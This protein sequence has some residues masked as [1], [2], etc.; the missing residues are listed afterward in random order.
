MN[1]DAIKAI[2]FRIQRIAFDA[3]LY[4]RGMCGNEMAKRR[5]DERKKLLRAIAELEHPQL[6]L[7]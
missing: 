5:S 2:R 4:D 7:L 6:P 1:K 3:N